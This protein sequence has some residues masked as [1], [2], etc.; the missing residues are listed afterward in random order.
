MASGN[1]RWLS[2]T[3]AATLLLLTGLA[4]PAAPASAVEPEAKFAF[5]LSSTTIALGSLKKPIYLRLTNLTDEAPEAISFS[6]GNFGPEWFFPVGGFRATVEWPERGG[7]GGCDG[8]WGS[9]G[10][11]I[12]SVEHPHLIPAPGGTVDIPLLITVS[13]NT[14]EPFEGEFGVSA[15]MSWDDRSPVLTSKRFTLNV[16]DNS[17]AD[18]SVKAWDVD[19]S[20]PV[21]P[22]PLEPHGPLNPGEAGGL[23]YLVA[24]HGRKAVS[25]LKVTIRLPEGVTFNQPEEAC[26]ID[27]DGRTAVCTYDSLA[28]VPV[29][30]ENHNEDLYS[31]VELGMVIDVPADTEAPVTLKGGMVQVEGLTEQAEAR[32]A[33]KRTRLPANAKAVPAADV[34]VSDNQDGFAVVV[35]AFP[36]D[37][38]G[39]GGGGLPVTGPP[40][41]LITGAGLAMLAVGG[42]ML[43]LARRRTRLPHA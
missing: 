18:L 11:D 30:E 32:S 36:K 27:S 43:L 35:A 38:G 24:N 2:R 15:G 40:A 7:A 12:N 28:L 22:G 6:V 34:D 41:G 8:D 13:T 9:W 37:D 10:C 20:V 17:E 39:G 26:V 42:I 29:E 5:E 19:Q 31:A 25:G 3:A 16:V 33:A 14:K 23:G 4:I 21:D 1:R